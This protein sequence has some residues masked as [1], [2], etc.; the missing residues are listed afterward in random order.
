MRIQGLALVAVIVFAGCHASVSANVKASGSAEQESVDQGPPEPGSSE[1]LVGEPDAEKP[2]TTTTALLGARHDLRL[3]ASV[4]TPTCTCLA[5]AIGPPDNASF[6]WNNGAPTVDPD[7]QEVVALSSQGVKCAAQ[8][9][10]DTLGASYWGYRVENNDVIVF[11]ENARFGRPIT[12]GAIIPKPAP[13]GHVYIEPASK[14]VPF[15]RPLSGGGNR[16]QLQ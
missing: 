1:P 5:A 16:C 13:G 4:T 15:G 12:A 6:A 10:K 9:P 8:I 3:A 7:S 11:V 14:D 2:P